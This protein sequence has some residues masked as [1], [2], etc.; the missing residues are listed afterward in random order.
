[1]D[2]QQDIAYGESND[3]VIDDITWPWKVKIV[4]QICLG[5]MGSI[6]SKTAGDTDSRLSYD[7]RKWHLGYRMFTCL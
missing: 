6:I 7:Y 2:Q 3:H 5:Q 4:I 1:M